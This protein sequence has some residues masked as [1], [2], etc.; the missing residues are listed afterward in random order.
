MKDF[1]FQLFW[2]RRGPTLRFDG[3]LLLFLRFY[4]NL[5]GHDYT[6]ANII[7]GRNSMVSGSIC[8]IYDDGVE[9]FH[10]TCLLACSLWALTS[11][12]KQGGSLSF[13][14][15]LFCCCYHGTKMFKIFG[16]KALRR[17]NIFEC[18]FF[19]YSAGQLRWD[20]SKKGLCKWGHF[21]R[22]KTTFKMLLASW[23][24]ACFFK[25][26]RSFNFINM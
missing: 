26:F 6:P 3:S 8:D 23:F 1:N 11:L 12:H 4:S 22:A 7:A 17:M 24:L 18:G 16:G 20:A 13:K 10:S 25:R 21:E 19:I 2:V 9:M 15:V 14:N 5:S